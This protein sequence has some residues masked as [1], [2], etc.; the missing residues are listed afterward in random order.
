[1]TLISR[2]CGGGGALPPPIMI[3]CGMHDGT[4]AGDPGGPKFIPCG[5][6]GSPAGGAAA[7]AG[8]SARRVLASPGFVSGGLDSP[9]L[10]SPGFTSAGFASPDFAASS[11]VAPGNGLIVGSTPAGHP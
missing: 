2:I 11:V 4:P 7:V 6:A 3:G 1:M 9:G 10:A 8:A 5:I